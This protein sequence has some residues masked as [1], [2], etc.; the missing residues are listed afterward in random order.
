[1]LRYLHNI[2]MLN[3]LNVAVERQFLGRTK[4]LYLVV[5]YLG[6]NNF[7]MDRQQIMDN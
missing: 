3:S 5:L 4:Q 1:M 6:K 7:F 2:A